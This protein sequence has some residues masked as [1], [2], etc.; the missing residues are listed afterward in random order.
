MSTELSPPLAIVWQMYSCVCLSLRELAGQNAEEVIRD[1][2]WGSGTDLGTNSE[3]LG[4]K[5]SEMCN[6]AISMI[7]NNL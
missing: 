5:L 7:H 4:L 1:Q 2:N 3:L 6:L